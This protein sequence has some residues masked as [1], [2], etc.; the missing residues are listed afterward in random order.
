MNECGACG[1]DFNGQRIFDAHRVGSH[2]HDYTPQRADGRRCLT[3]SE[4]R[5]RGWTL[6]RHG[7]WIDPNRSRDVEARQLTSTAVSVDGVGISAPVSRARPRRSGH[8]T[9]SS[10]ADPVTPSTSRKGGE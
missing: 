2:A 1:Q 7:R 6:N 5:Q 8:V 3:V 4:M 9:R 10:T